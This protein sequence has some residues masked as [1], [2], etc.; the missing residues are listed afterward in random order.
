MVCTIRRCGEMGNDDIRPHAILSEGF[1]TVDTGEDEGTGLRRS[2]GFQ[3]R[4]G[5][6]RLS[7]M[8]SHVCGLVTNKSCRHTV[9]VVCL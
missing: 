7:P 2:F 1:R 9:P 4:E 3:S 8:R 6:T 5:G